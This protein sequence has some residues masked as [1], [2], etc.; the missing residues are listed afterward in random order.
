MTFY[1]IPSE[2]CVKKKY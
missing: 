2:R 1:P